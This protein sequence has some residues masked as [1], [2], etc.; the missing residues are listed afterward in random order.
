K[1][2]FQLKNKKIGGGNFKKIIQR[3]YLH[4]TKQSF[5]G[6]PASGASGRLRPQALGLSLHGSAFT[7]ETGSSFGVHCHQQDTT[8]R[9]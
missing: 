5:A 3:V 6:T 4:P 9:R 7:L 8:A 2:P 1:H